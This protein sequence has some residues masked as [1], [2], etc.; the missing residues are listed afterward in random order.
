MERQAQSFFTVMGLVFMGLS[1]AAFL[2][3][4]DRATFSLK[5]A[6]QA[7]GSKPPPEASFDVPNFAPLGAAPGFAVAS[8]LCFLASS[9]AGLYGRLGAPPAPPEA[10]KPPPP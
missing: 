1:V 5:P 8:G 3:W 2:G 4:N 10:P 6:Q 7:V 9:I